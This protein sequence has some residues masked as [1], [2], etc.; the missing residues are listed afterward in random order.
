MISTLGCF[1]RGNSLADFRGRKL[2]DGN[3]RIS[4]D[5][6]TENGLSTEGTGNFVGIRKFWRICNNRPPATQGVRRHFVGVSMEGFR[7][8]P[9]SSF[10]IFA[11]TKWGRFSRPFPWKCRNGVRP[12]NF[13]LQTPNYYRIPLFRSLCRQKREAT[14]LGKGL[15]YTEP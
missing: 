10:A 13:L 9:A 7:R 2:S 4:V 11:N 1:Q 5:V 3:P 8:G 12:R 14:R 6:F 15:S